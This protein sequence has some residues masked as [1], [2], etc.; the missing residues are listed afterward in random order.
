MDVSQDVHID[1]IVNLQR[2]FIVWSVY[3]TAKSNGEMDVNQDVHL[4]VYLHTKFNLS[5]LC[6]AAS[7]NGEMDV[8]TMSI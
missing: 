1:L 5:S 6:Q 8:K 7:S 2:I 3:L 4:I